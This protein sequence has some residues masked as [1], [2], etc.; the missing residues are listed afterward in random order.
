MKISKKLQSEIISFMDRYWDSYIKDDFRKWVSFL[1]VSYKNIGT[2]KQTIGKNKKE[3]M[4][5]TG[6]I[7]GE[8]VD[9]FEIRG[10]QTDIFEMTPYIMVQ[11]V[12]DVYLKRKADWTFFSKLRLS[13]ILQKNGSGWK[14]IHQ[15][16]SYP[17]PGTSGVGAFAYEKLRKQNV[18]LHNAI[19]RR[20]I[21]LE[22]KNRELEIDAALER[23]RA[24][25]MDMRKSGELADTAKVLFEQIN[26]LGKIPDRMS[27][28]IINERTRKAELW[29]TDQEGNQLNNEYCF[30]LDEPTSISK[31]YTA[32][33]EKKD[34][35]IVDLNDR[36]LEDWLKYVIEDAKLPIDIS[37]IKGRR[38]HQAAFF[39]K[40]YLLCH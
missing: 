35:I 28:G 16:G 22:S 36:N 10:K 38:V 2:T 8:M 11:E 20:T 25:A 4:K 15:Q 27:I 5:F 17:E 21:E 7:D 23:V 31:F 40:G 29:L 24:R 34:S 9:K 3:I 30:S 37:K 6:E 26:S 12:G 32:W 33:K 13:S 18:K 39:S 14:I 19:K 1:S